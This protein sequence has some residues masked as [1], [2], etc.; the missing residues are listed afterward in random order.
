MIRS[1]LLA[2]FALGWTGLATAADVLVHQQDQVLWLR[3]KIEINCQTLEALEADL[4]RERELVRKQTGRDVLASVLPE[5]QLLR[6]ETSSTSSQPQR[7]TRALFAALDRDGDGRLTPEEIRT[8]DTRLLRKFDADEDDCLTA[9]EIV[10][11]LLNSSALEPRNPSTLRLELLP[12]GQKPP[13]EKPIAE[14]TVRL[15]Q[16][17]LWHGMHKNMRID[18]AE[19]LPLPEETIIPRALRAPGREAERKLVERALASRVTLVWS[20]QPRG[21][22]ERLDSDSDGQL[23][24]PELRQAWDRLADVEARKR[25]YLTL[26]DGPECTLTVVAGWSVS[27]TTPLR[28]IERVR[29]GPGWFR[30]MDRNADGVV[31]VREFLGAREEFNQFDCDADGLITPA[32]AEAGER[33]QQRQGAR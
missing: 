26:H 15:G 8:A 32:E 16:A 12:A 22:F 28:R 4:A 5:G 21:W 27:P 17:A 19:F 14:I 11:D 2:L 10:P 23:S 33:K 6:L 24:V 30:A 13:N 9:L 7:L 25:G 20:D 1:G 29:S 18:V 31:S 3:L